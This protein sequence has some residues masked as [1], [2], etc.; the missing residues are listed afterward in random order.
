MAIAAGIVLYLVGLIV[1]MGSHF[2]KKFKRDGVG[3]GEG[4]TLLKAAVNYF[5]VTKPF[6]TI[7]AFIGYNVGFLIFVTG[8]TTVTGSVLEVNP[9]TIIAVIAVG[10]ACDS[11][12]NKGE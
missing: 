8:I 7:G 2:I 6:H 9:A 4:I 1:G 10:A 3:T 12:F 5:F 11:N